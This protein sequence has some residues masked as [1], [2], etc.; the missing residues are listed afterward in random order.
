MYM[1]MCDMLWIQVPTTTH[2]S[3][4]FLRLI[5]IITCAY[6]FYNLFNVSFN[7]LIAVCPAAIS[8]S[9]VN[10]LMAIGGSPYDRACI[11]SVFKSTELVGGRPLLPASDVTGDD[12]GDGESNEMIASIDGG[13]DGKTEIISNKNRCLNKM[14]KERF[15]VHWF[16]VEDVCFV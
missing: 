10:G 11:T 6:A 12:G 3:Q 15:I 1:I 5:A 14:A 4:S 2:I 9:V 13:C 7:L 8:P 16:W